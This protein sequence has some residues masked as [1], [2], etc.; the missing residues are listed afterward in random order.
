MSQQI[1]RNLNTSPGLN[2]AVL[3]QS[4]NALTPHGAAITRRFYEVLFAQFPAVEPLFANTTI[5]EQYRK[6]WA[7]LKLVVSVLRKPEELMT[8]LV[9]LRQRHAQ[10]GAKA[11]YYPAMAETLLGVMQDL[12]G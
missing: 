8:T 7:A 6:L 11:E 12:R 3:E 1:Q 10:I 9:K 2:V 4:F 5:D